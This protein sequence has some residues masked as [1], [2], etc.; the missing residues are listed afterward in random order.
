ML[1]GPSN[2]TANEATLITFTA[3]AAD[4][5]LPAQ[6]LAYSL[7]AGA[8]AGANV[9]ASSGV[10]AWTPT[11]AQGPS[12]NTITIRVTDNG[13]SALSDAKSF[14]VIVNEVNQAPVL[15]GIT[16]RT[17]SIGS[18]V[19]FKAEAHDD[20]LPLQTLTFLLGS[21]APA[22]AAIEPLT[23]LFSWIPTTAG[24]NT[25]VLGVNDN[26]NPQMSAV[27]SFIIVVKGNPKAP[28]ITKITA[29]QTGL[30]SVYWDAEP[31]IVYQLQ[32]KLHAND[33]AWENDGATVTVTGTQAMTA[34]FRV[35]GLQ[36]YYRIV[37]IDPP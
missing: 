8:P 13:T 16:N 37:V 25:I 20:D 6:T 36:G 26:G 7:D 1:T 33:A 30:V 23:G 11:E 31:G 10:F 15:T 9:N 17:V 18:V 24:T 12:T 2:I 32:Y 3:H 19:S 27:Q 21:G 5:D 34:D 35:G 28:R 4:G 22:G 14:T 29:P